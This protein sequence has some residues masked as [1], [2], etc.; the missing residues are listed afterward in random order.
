MGNEQL[1]C[2]EVF[3]LMRPSEAGKVETFIV[4]P[5]ADSFQRMTAPEMPPDSFFGGKTL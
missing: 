5:K 1:L 4:D 3:V 2:R